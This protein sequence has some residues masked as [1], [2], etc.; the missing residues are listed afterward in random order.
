MGPISRH[1][2]PPKLDGTD[3]RD[4]AIS[5]LLKEDREAV[6]A[7]LNAIAETMADFS[8]KCLQAGAHGIFLSVRDD[9]VERK[10]N[11]DV[12]YADLVRPSDAKVLDA[13]QGA[14]FNFLHMCGKPLNFLEFGEF[15]V[16]VVN[17]ADRA[18]GPSIAYARDRVKPAIAGGV[19]NLS[20][21]PNGTPEDC[22]NE[23]KDAL[24]QAK[25]RPIMITPGCTYD[26]NVVPAENL[27]AIVAAARGQM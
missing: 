16:Q 1:H 7:A 18:A 17:W 19:D 14:P 4:E 24:R 8:A 15:P 11:E 5:R 25:D 13:V 10:E 20:T 22:A 3:E 23:V 12:R 27:K 9:W 21:M 26:P 2:A 6:K